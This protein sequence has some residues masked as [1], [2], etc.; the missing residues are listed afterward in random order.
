MT[1]ADPF[2]TPPPA[3]DV[4]TLLREG[5]EDA[6]RGERASARIKFERVVELDDRNEKGWFWLAS[7][8]DTDE[9]RRAALDKVLEINPNNDRARKALDALEAR[10]DAAQA[11]AKPTPS[12]EVIPGVTRRQLTLVIGVGAGI[13][14]VLAILLIAMLGVNSGSQSAS[15]TQVASNN[16]ATISAETAVAQAATQA[17]VDATA[18]QFAIATPI[19]PTSDR[20]TLPPEWTATPPP[21]AVPTA[22]SIP[23]PVG[24]SGLLSAWGGRDLENVGFLPVGVINLNAGTGFERVGDSLG[25]DVTIYANGQRIAYTLYDRVFFA[26]NL[27]AVNINGASVENFGERFNSIEVIEP[28]MPSYSEDGASLV[29][30][31][32]TPTSGEGRQ[33]FQLSLV[34]SSLRNLTNDGSDYSYP[35][36]SPDSRRVIAVRNDLASGHGVDLAVVD[37]ATG[38]K[39]AVTNDQNTILETNPRWTPDGS[40]I[41]FAAAIASEP[42]N[43]DLYLR[44]ADGSGTSSPLAASGDD[45][46]FP[47]L[48]PD[49]RFLA[50]ASNRGGSYQI[51]TLDLQQQTLGQL[52]SNPLENFFPGDWWAP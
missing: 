12:K 16:L 1:D 13:T 49:A 24:V 11:A 48:S 38:G 26:T 33:I 17:S 7:V 2:S 46:I 42:D 3:N 30:V 27:Q 31:A 22:E 19:P 51:Y 43:H 18:T 29:F 34:D 37:I 20:P 40:Q 23:L 6:R 15:L 5:I 47:V 41:V 39:Y 21:T 32:R 8:L 36:I 50:Y 28:E 4:E 35:H 25:R 52:T 10:M 9:E 44:N 14:A 45:E